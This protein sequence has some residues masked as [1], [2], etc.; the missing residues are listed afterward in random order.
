MATST[1]ELH[2]LTSASLGPDDSITLYENPYTALEKL[3]DASKDKE[4][5]SPGD[6][7]RV[8]WRKYEPPVAL[9][10]APTIKS[11]ILL[12]VIF[13]SIENVKSRVGEE[14]RLLKEAAEETERR[15]AE[16]KQKAKGKEPYL[17]VIIPT[18][19]SPIESSL[20]N[21]NTRRTVASSTTSDFVMSTGNGLPA[22]AEK[23][24]KFGLR[25]IFLRSPEGGESSAAGRSR[26]AL[27]H[28]L[29]TKVLSFDAKSADPKTQE[30]IAVLRKVKLLK[31]VDADEL[32][33]CVSCL[34][35]IPV[36]DTVKVPCHSY[37]RDCFARLVSAAVQ[38]EQ[39]WPPKCCLNQIPFK[40]VLK[41][42]P[43]DLKKTFHERSSEWEMPIS[44]RVYCY[45]PDCGSWIKPGKIS[46]A[47]R[48]ARCE[49]NHVTCTICR[50][51]AHGNNDCPQ[52]H[53]LNLT[54]LL[55][56]E[57][58]WK[59][60]ISCHALVEHKEACQHMTCRCGAEFCYVCGLRW[61]TC[62]CTTEQLRAIKEAAKARREQRLLTEQAD[63]E[64]LR[65]I[66][67]QI[68]ESERQEALRLVAQRLEQ[69]R[70][71]QERWRAEA[72]ERLRLEEIRRRDVEIKYRQLRDKLDKLHELQH[73][74]ADSKQ[75]DDARDLAT[76][77]ELEKKRLEEKHQAERKELDSLMLLK[78][79]AREDQ[80]E[81]EYAA[82]VKLERQLEDGYLEQ[83]REF[84]SGKDG[85]EEKI[86][87]CMQ[88]LRQRMDSAYQSW[89][90]WRDDQ[91]A[92]YRDGL[93]DERTAK[94]DF[95]YSSS[96]R[97]DAAHLNKETELA[98][99]IVAEKKWIREVMLERER[100]LGEMEIQETEDD[101]DSLYGLEL[102]E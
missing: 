95:M 21:I 46:L 94:E 36:K 59:H 80:Y 24:R 45:A 48:Q 14:E 3:Q 82:R 20:S 53:D 77:A 83:L 81:K 54:N 22:K 61:R 101:A 18:E 71:E 55:A 64:E 12:D 7:N 98:R 50:G 68:E 93:E 63:A 79:G 92:H 13:S 26:E 43:D 66:L 23:R 62:G 37:C 34:D 15:T 32:V 16:E 60:C 85:G 29:E 90:R 78:L 40:T 25:N 47:K 102:D 35:D 96:K 9:R 42:I 2:T 84:W 87:A 4:I 10:K 28:K 39:Q 57:E 76:K 58:G 88:P 51:Q 67:A 75:E 97:L 70:L 73:V 11:H 41:N 8:D 99:R 91:L 19:D 44:E 27:R 33:E 69:E 1:V 100:L 89:Q 65:E 31:T 74:M 5:E 30:A 56:E 49:R 86:E 72:E 38:Y 52:D 6:V 17:P